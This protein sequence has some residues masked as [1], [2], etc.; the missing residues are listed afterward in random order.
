VAEAFLYGLIG[1]AALLLGAAIALIW[2]IPDRLLGAIM[3]FG[4]GVLISAVSFELVEEADATTDA[5]WSIA[6][7]LTAGALVF[8]FGDMAIDRA[9]GA[10]RKSSNPTA[11]E[12]G[13]AAILLGTVLD[14]IPESIVIGLGLIAGKGVSVAMVAAV[15]LSN[16]PE[17]IG[18]TSGLRASGW[19]R[20][21]L[22]SMWGGVALIAGISSLLGFTLFDGA[23]DELVALVLAFAAGALLTMLV[24]TMVPEAF[25]LNGPAAGLLTTLG[26]GLAYAIGAL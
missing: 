21:R 23:S 24:D 10:E 9:G 13:G 8:F 16:L 19:S 14:G 7:G 22:F 11:T 3:A 4:S 5:G 18:A 1:G 26:F 25:A 6:L 12:Q 20:T 15:F 17:A 2:R